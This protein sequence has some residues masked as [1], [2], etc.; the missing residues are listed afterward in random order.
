[1]KE[2]DGLGRFVKNCNPWNAGKAL[3]FSPGTVFKTGHV[4]ANRK[5]D[6]ALTVRRTKG[7]A[8]LWVR[9]AKNNWEMYSRYL[10]KA[11]HGPIPPGHVVIFKNGDAMD[12]RPENLSVISMAANARRNADP[13]KSRRSHLANREEGMRTASERL[14]DNYVASIL[15]VRDPELISLKRTNLLLNREIRNYEKQN[16]GCTEFDDPADGAV[17]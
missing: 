6:G 16:A 10:W 4:P 3:C 8:Y 2:R 13:A 1:M 15:G 14:T 5:W 11:W 7:R 9:V 12:C 17:G